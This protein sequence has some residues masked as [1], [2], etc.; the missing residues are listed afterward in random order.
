MNLII[1]KDSLIAKKNRIADESPNRDNKRFAIMTLGCKVNKYESEAMEELLISKGYQMV[2][3]GE[4]ADINIINTCTVTAMSDKK[5]RQ[6]IRRAKKINPNSVVVVMGCFSQKNPKEVLEIDEVNLVL[7]T[8]QRSALIDELEHATSTD[9]KIIVD[10]IMK[11]RD[12]EEM[13]ISQV[14]DRT[15]AL[16]KIQDGCDRFCSYC[17]IPY[18]R[19]PVRSRKLDNILREV[20]RLAQNGYKEVVLTGI[21]VASYG[22]DIGGSLADVILEIGKIDG[23]ERIR[24][25]SVEPLV[26]T[27]E[28][29]QA[30][31]SVAKFCPHFHLSMQSGS[32]TVLKRMNRR[33]NSKEYKEAVRLI[34]EYYEEASIT[35]DVIVGF[36]G[37]TEQEF[38]ETKIL[39]EELKLYETHIFKYSPREGTKAFR[40]KDD[41][42][43]Q[44]KS[45]RSS[46][47]ISLSEQNKKMYQERALGQSLEV[48]FET[49]DG[50]YYY[51]HTKN[52][53]KVAVPM[54]GEDLTNRVAFVLAQ[55]LEEDFIVGTVKQ[56]SKED[57]V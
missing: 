50:R 2:N 28:F 46:S 22:K 26:I 1:T 49:S 4:N 36:P 34:R 54:G 48:L 30:V 45:E 14:S 37:E 18:T 21:H 9:K 6:M 25:S 7:G 53:L 57:G 23:I 42:F 24:T 5:S 15:R 44:K 39:L 41:V 17:I 19:G 43:P 12:F 52:Y 11:I 56:H 29:M 55:S 32:D 10:D 47:L 20:E 33:Y 27:K 35:T 38:E 3:F 13:T 16:I 51:G 31:S 8:N 40:W